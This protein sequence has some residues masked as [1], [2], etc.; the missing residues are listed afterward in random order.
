MTQSNEPDPGSRE[1][2][3]EYAT[4]QEAAAGLARLSPSELGRI[5]L[6]ARLL[7]RGTTMEPHEVINTVVERLLTRDGKYGRHWHRKET[8]TDC[9]HRTM[10]SIV[11][12]Y[13]RRRQTPMIAISDTAA[14]HQAE[15]DPE[16]QMAAR[17][18]LLQVLRALGDDDNTA[19][20]ALALASGN[21][22]AEVRKRY[23]L[24]EIGYES[25]LKRIRRRL[26]KH[27]M[28]GDRS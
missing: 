18:E 12:D 8:L 7:V 11:R 26:A 20:I 14:G 19:A 5:E 2:E 28:S 1:S 22:P 21:S 9:F 24:S 4:V 25:A 3:A 10:K 6:R 16:V 13:W 23:G 27:K 17:D 15:P